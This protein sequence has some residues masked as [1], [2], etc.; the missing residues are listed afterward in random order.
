M[1]AII[2][3]F[4]LLLVLMAGLVSAQ[5]SVK[6]IPRDNNDLQLGKGNAQGGFMHPVQSNNIGLISK[7]SRFSQIGHYTYNGR[8]Y[9]KIG[10]L[11]NGRTTFTRTIQPKSKW[12]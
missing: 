6:G 2:F 11:T 5:R 10:D 8:R 7:G 4:T 9:F 12:L 3:S 1:K